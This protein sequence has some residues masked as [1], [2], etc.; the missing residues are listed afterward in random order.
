[1]HDTWTLLLCVLAGSALG[2][3]FFGGLWWTVGK[4]L[5]SK[6]TALWLIGSLFVRTGIVLTGFYWMGAGQ[7][8]R[9]LAGFAGFFIARIIVM[10][11]TNC[12]HSRLSQ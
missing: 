1:M 3:I 5:S 12:S 10:K 7:W 2:V 9:Y 6:H 11:V 4:S 8:E